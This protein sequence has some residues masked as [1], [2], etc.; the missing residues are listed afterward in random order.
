MLI[1]P[2]KRKCFSKSLLFWAP[3]KA[4]PSEPW[5]LSFTR[6][7]WALLACSSGTVSVIF[8]LSRTRVRLGTHHDIFPNSLINRDKRGLF[9]IARLIGVATL[10]SKV[11]GLAREAALA[12][13]FGVGPV[14]NAFNYASI[15]PGFFLTMLGGINGPFHTA[16]TAALS[17]RQKK[18]GQHLVA[19]ITLLAGL[20]CTG[21]SL[22][23]FLYAAQL[24]NALA[25]GLSVAADGVLTQQIA[26]LQVPY[27]Y[28]KVSWCL[29]Y[30]VH[31]KW[32][33]TNTMMLW[34]NFQNIGVLLITSPGNNICIRVLYEYLGDMYKP[35]KI[36]QW[37]KICST[38]L[39]VIIPVFLWQCS[40]A[41]SYGST[42]IACSTFLA[43]ANRLLTSL[44]YLI[45]T[46]WMC[47]NDLLN[48]RVWSAKYF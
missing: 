48:L 14:I 35:A 23:I 47:W 4:L 2:R 21:L 20:F 31:D 10:A 45:G 46:K 8:L 1:L 42:L 38:R 5:E 9:Q 30:T 26:V 13:V 16:M 34:L 6:G 32:Y 41:E 7:D 15:V 36:Q 40:S 43:L 3:L 33:R 19:S 29:I 28:Q 39:T 27:S 44:L 22:L 18:E 25:P 11:I 24:I 37:I 17:K 12:A